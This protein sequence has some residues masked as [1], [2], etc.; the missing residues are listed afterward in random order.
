MG[1]DLWFH[2]SDG[3]PRPSG[4]AVLEWLNTRRGY[5][6]T[7]GAG[8]YDNE[9]TGARFAVHV[10][11]NDG[12]THDDRGTHDNHDEHDDDSADHDDDHGGPA[13]RACVERDRAAWLDHVVGHR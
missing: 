2:A 10:D 9:S 13:C 1:Y 11:D 8:Y 5:T 3:H 7:D 12:G 4:A 6:T